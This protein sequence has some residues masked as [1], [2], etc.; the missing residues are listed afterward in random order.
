MSFCA[1]KAILERVYTHMPSETGVAHAGK[2]LGDFAISTKHIRQL[3]A[4]VSLGWP[5]SAH[6][7]S[8]TIDHRSIQCQA[9]QLII[10]VADQA[11]IYIPRFC[12]HPKL[13]V[14]ANCRMCLVEIAKSPKPLPACAT[15]VSEGMCVYTR[16]RMAL[17]AQ[18]DIMS[19]LLI[20][21]P[22]DCPIC[23]QGGECDLQDLALGYGMAKGQFDE[24]KR[25]LK[26]KI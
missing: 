5:M 24:A 4:T 14:A 6:A 9:G 18:K 13:T 17:K 16:S 21:H 20:N 2:G 22:L 3:A 8:I 26:M 25:L 7:I 23:D 11:G 1:F 10:E 19:F 15:P 12:Y